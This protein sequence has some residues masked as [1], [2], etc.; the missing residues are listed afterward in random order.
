MS[1]AQMARE[2][3]QLGH[4][5]TFNTLRKMT[6]EQLQGQLAMYHTKAEARVPT[7]T[8]MTA[9]VESV[10]TATIAPPI[11][12]DAEIRRAAYATIP[13]ATVA[14]AHVPESRL[15]QWVMLAAQPIMI[16]R[17]MIGV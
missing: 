15:Y 4:P 1:K 6:E 16:L 9:Y 17:G 13:V 10:P 3:V 14:P 5:K 8:E 7:S 12:T 11:P 2:L